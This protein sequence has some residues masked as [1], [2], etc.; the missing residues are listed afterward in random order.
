VNRD[1][2]FLEMALRLGVIT[3]QQAAWLH[4]VREQN[5]QG[6]LE[7]FLLQNQYLSAL[8]IQQVL[9]P[10]S[11][12]ASDSGSGIEP[13]ASSRSGSGLTNSKDSH[14]SRMR[15]ALT[16]GSGGLEDGVTLGGYSIIEEIARGGMGAVYR[17]QKPGDDEVVALK[18]MLTD[19]NV[20]ERQITR[21][22][23]EI[24]ANTKLKHPHI[25]K[26]LDSGQEGRR[27]YYTM[28]LVEGG[29][30]GSVIGNE[31]YQIEDKVKLMAAVA[32]AVGYAHGHGV[33]HRDLKPDNILLTVDGEPKV[34]DFGLAKSLLG[35][36]DL[37]K[38]GSAV[39][40][41]SYMAP[42][43]VRGETKT[44]D[45]R[46]DVWALG[47]IAY[48]MVSGDLPFKAAGI[49]QLY[50]TIL[51]KEHIDLSVRFSRAK[52]GLSQVINRCLEKD[53]ENRY[54]TGLELAEDLE[55]W[56][57]Q[58]AVAVD[59]QSHASRL[60]RG[61]KRGKVAIMVPLLGILLLVFGGVGFY[62][63]TQKADR[64]AAIKKRAELFKD[65][66]RFLKR[67]AQ[68]C[69]NNCEQGEGALDIDDSDAARGAFNEAMRTS[70]KSLKVLERV[71]AKQRAELEQGEAYLALKEQQARAV[72]G[73]ARIASRYA[74]SNDERT[75]ALLALQEMNEPKFE[76]QRLLAKADLEYQLQRYETSR[77]T[78]MSWRKY[79]SLPETAELLL[80][81]LYFKEGSLIPALKSFEN[82]LKKNSKMTR[83]Y[84]A[85]Q[86][87]NIRL[88]RDATG[89]FKRLKDLYKKDPKA[90]FDLVLGY[91]Q[92]PDAVYV[93]GLSFAMGQYRKDK[94]QIE[95]GK[96]LA[97][98]YLNHC[99]ADDSLEILRDCL[100][101]DN[102]D[103][104]TLLFVFFAHC[105]NSDWKASE[106]I[107]KQLL[108]LKEPRPELIMQAMRIHKAIQTVLHKQQEPSIA[109][110]LLETSK[111]Q[112]QLAR[113]RT[114][115]I[116]DQLSEIFLKERAAGKETFRPAD[117]DFLAKFPDSDDP[118]LRSALAYY[119]GRWG[120][121]K[122]SQ[123]YSDSLSANAHVA[124]LDRFTKALLSQGKQDLKEA[125]QAF[126]GDRASFSA[127]LYRRANSLI[128]RSFGL[129]NEADY[130][131]A[132]RLL[133]IARAMDPWALPLYEL[134]ACAAVERN[135]V[136]KLEAVVRQWHLIAPYDVKALTY[137]AAL[138]IA[139]KDFKSAEALCEAAEKKGH[140]SL[141]LTMNRVKLYEK[142]KS[143]RKILELT[144]AKLSTNFYQLPLLKA[145]V[146]A[147]K[148]LGRNAKEWT[149]EKE[150]VR[151]F[152]D[153][154]YAKES[155]DGLAEV[156]QEDKVKAL[157]MAK[158]ATAMQPKSADCLLK[159]A[160][161][162]KA[163][164]GPEN[165]MRAYLDLGEIF[166]QNYNLFDDPEYDFKNHIQYVLPPDNYY[167]MIARQLKTGKAISSRQAWTYMLLSYIEVL[168]SFRK[169]NSMRAVLPY[170]D[171]ALQGFPENISVLFLYG[172]TRILLGDLGGRT[173]LRR[174]LKYN[175]THGPA[176]LALA[177]VEARNSRWDA[178]FKFLEKA[179][180]RAGIMQKAQSF[181]AFKA[182]TKMARWKKLAK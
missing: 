52:S 37:T 65:A 172:W 46:C 38:T 142:S 117:S 47:V 133:K 68:T 175:P 167:K 148:N 97:V 44:T 53:P 178:A 51:T 24:E 160:A 73:M 72:L 17:A 96:Q 153:E 9:D 70:E 80:A 76:K 43:Q 124:P 27:L 33:F 91:F 163:Q 94:S 128:K 109:A 168:N 152:E 78:L 118:Y 114:Q 141:L 2:Q 6:H 138:Q 182:M 132:S 116:E 62:L 36:S 23:R 113:V 92:M 176:L 84:R 54:R 127:M 82:V 81:E 16:K 108:E 149:R 45:Q 135:E 41:P 1:Q 125:Y 110:I 42:E 39:G 77:R 67:G 35:Q 95:L 31:E 120:D 159:R 10:G 85:Q 8:Q 40:T 57:E 50:E 69:S 19:E 5:P 71:D 115:H 59:G 4:D 161:T 56:L 13:P 122:L 100:I 121:R 75:K 14:Q 26:L 64:E 119:H 25:I 150:C 61:I 28:E 74:I 164:G 181:K 102:K 165:M 137:M 99:R 103:S 169:V 146:K 173:Q 136:K 162:W 143:H 147:F 174:C 112:K 15:K 11:R 86:L 107:L 170:M 180:N 151:G 93:K 18:I 154:D 60:V 21:F 179:K 48:Q 34:T 131:K 139:N 49:P 12:A 55:T 87:I 30:L 22:Q 83:A 145:R 106:E 101:R 134:H 177:L 171:R 104:E 32:R 7:Q 155:M 156:V 123:R 157:E 20:E 88:G 166:L 158:H 126:I 3:Q 79:G 129:K 58:G 90:L 144:G 66:H 98:A 140:E 63:W 111:E 29:S 105:L 130:V 89:S